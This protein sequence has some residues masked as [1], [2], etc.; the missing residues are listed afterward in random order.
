M[1]P[2]CVGYIPES[3]K[4]QIPPYIGQDNLFGALEVELGHADLIRNS[5]LMQWNMEVL[6]TSNYSLKMGLQE[7]IRIRSY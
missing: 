1:G 3:P 6:N 2:G 4:N 5:S 7:F